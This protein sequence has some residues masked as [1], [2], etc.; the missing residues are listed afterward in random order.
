M[1]RRDF[2][3]ATAA[4]AAGPAL[5]G[6]SGCRPDLQLPGRVLG[7]N[8][9]MGHRLRQ[10]ASGAGG[11]VPKHELQHD[12]VVAGGGIAG[13][14]AARKLRQLGFEKVA[15]VELEQGL[16]GTSAAGQNAVSAYPLGAHYVPLPGKDCHEVLAFFQEIG[17]ITGHDA[18]GRPVY[19]EMALCHDPQERLFLHGEWHE[20]LLPL[21]GLPEAERA[22]FAR[23]HEIVEHYQKRR[24]FTLPLDRSLREPALLELDKQT[25]LSWFIDS[26][27]R[28]EKLRWSLNYACLDDFGGGLDEVSAWA[29]LHYFCSRAGEAANARPET[30]LTWPQGNGWLVEQLRS[31]LDAGCCYGG[32]LVARAEAAGQG[33]WLDAVDAQTGEVTRHRARALVCALPRFIAQRVIAGTPKVAGLEYAPW[34]VMNVTVDELPFS[35]GVLPAWDNVVYGQSALGYVN[36][37]HQKLESRPSATVISHYEALS[38]AG[39]SAVQWREWM[40]TQSHQQWAG[41]LLSSLAAPHPDLARHI[42][43]LDVWLWGHGMIRPRPGYLWGAERQILLQNLPPIFYAHS[44]MSGMA[45]FEEAYTRGVLAAEAVRHWLS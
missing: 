25:M 45:L 28:S 8:H 15:V 23:F 33:V 18:A 21:T 12:V 26:G 40:L 41:R 44:D 10:L 34:V 20:G 22:E 13:L 4:G 38:G 2:L 1:K 37:G 14:A 36:A 3:K 31:G 30:M 16:G 19:D 27:F 17:L 39:R 29:G 43:Q 5:V 7:P 35:P 32:Q 42:Q 24:A 6:L 9:A 11:L